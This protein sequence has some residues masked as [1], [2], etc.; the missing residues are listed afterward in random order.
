MDDQEETTQDESLESEFELTPEFIRDIA[1]R[2]YPLL[3]ERL[4]LEREQ[5]GNMDSLIG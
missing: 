1:D 2:V 3:L 4:R 5:M